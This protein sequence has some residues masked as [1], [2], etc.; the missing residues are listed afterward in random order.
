MSAIGVGSGLDRGLHHGVQRHAM[1]PAPL[2]CPLDGA[3][4]QANPALDV[5]RHQRAQ[6][7]MQRAKVLKLAK[8]RPHHLLDLFV[9]IIPYPAGRGG[10]SPRGSAQLSAPRRAF[11]KVP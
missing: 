1:G 4:P 3:F 11:C 6:E 9:R 5:V 8:D 7:R 10:T 2:Q